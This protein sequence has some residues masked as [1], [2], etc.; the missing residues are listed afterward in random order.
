[1]ALWSIGCLRGSSDAVPLECGCHLASLLVLGDLVFPIRIGFPRIRRGRL[2]GT[3]QQIHRRCHDRCRMTGPPIRWTGLGL[4][5]AV[6]GF[7][8][9]AGH[10]GVKTVV[11]WD[12]ILLMR[13]DG[14][15]GN[16]DE[17]NMLSAFCEVDVVGVLGPTRA[18]Q[19][20]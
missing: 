11:R 20:G 16:F 13:F 4:R 6:E 7:P 15:R 2:Q 3:I 12:R 9:P 19:R 14:E 17:G 8:P 1:M 10:C 5:P 18:S